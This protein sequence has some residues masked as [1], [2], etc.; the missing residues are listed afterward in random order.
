MINPFTANPDPFVSSTCTYLIHEAASTSATMCYYKLYIFSTCGHSTNSDKPVSICS[1]LRAKRTSP[2]QSRHDSMQVDTFAAAQDS[3][4]TKECIPSSSASHAPT[5]SSPT[6]NE[7]HSSPD[8]ADRSTCTTKFAHPFQSYR[9]PS[10]CLLCESVQKQR[11]SHLESNNVIEIDEWRWR[12]KFLNPVPEGRR[13][14]E[15]RQAGQMF[16]SWVKGFE[17]TAWKGYPKETGER[18]RDMDTD[19]SKEVKREPSVEGV[20]GGLPSY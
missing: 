10:L 12:I 1:P 20:R 15:W 3:N 19:T 8:C 16:G 14:N 6:H 7:T 5:S 2:P 13:W 4:H 11:L 9:I 17:D 18:L